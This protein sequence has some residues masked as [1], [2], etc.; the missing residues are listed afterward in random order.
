MAKGGTTDPQFNLVVYAKNLPEKL[1][2]ILSP[3][4]EL[5]FKKISLIDST[6]LSGPH[7]SCDS[8]SDDSGDSESSDD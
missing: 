6:I 8:D 3:D 4:G 7:Q 5:E 2:F 1:L